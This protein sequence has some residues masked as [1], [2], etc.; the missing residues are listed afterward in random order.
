MLDSRGPSHHDASMKIV[1]S[2]GTRVDYDVVGA[3]PALLLLHGFSFDRTMWSRSGWIERLESDHRVV[4][5]DLR[6]CGNSDKPLVPSAYSLDAHLADIEAVL[7]E[8]A[9]ERPVVW[10]WSFGATLALHFAKRGRVAATVAAG[11]Y[12]GRIF[13]P[14]YVE[15]RRSATTSELQ[16]A[17]WSGLESC[18]A[19]EPDEICGPLLVYT[20]TRDGNVVR[21]LQRQRGSIEKTGG[22]LHVLEGLNHMELVT[23]VAPVG[24]VVLPFIQRVV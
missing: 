14:A 4:S 12:F 9:I 13:T 1:A 23:A 24:A 6:G 3:G 10:G 15:A 20:G 5:L 7:E 2:D 16:R 11:T 8:L 22:M 18:P 17:R 21:E 19:I